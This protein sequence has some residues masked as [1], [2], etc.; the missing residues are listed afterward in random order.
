MPNR[1]T[2]ERFVARVE[3]NAHAD[4]IAE[5]YADNPSMQENPFPGGA[6]PE[7]YIGVDPAGSVILSLRQS[8]EKEPS[9]G[10]TQLRI[11]KTPARSRQEA[12][13]GRKAQAQGRIARTAVR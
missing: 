3:E 10:Q 12:E 8:I 6:D 11:R 4:A 1:E 9:I 5:F 13:T 7:P 2:L